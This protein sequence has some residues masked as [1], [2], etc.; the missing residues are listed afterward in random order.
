VEPTSVRI[1]MMDS[2]RPG[3]VVLLPARHLGPWERFRRAFGRMVVVSGIALFI[4]NFMLLI[5][6]APHVHLCS[7]PLSII[8]GPLVAF[9]SWRQ[10]V[11]LGASEIACVRCRKPVAVPANH[12]GWPARMNCLHCGI[13]VELTLAA[14]T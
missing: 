14:P 7:L 6:P 10:R 4:S 8:L 11:L 3:E 13:M 12:P 2:T 9:L 5:V 1:G